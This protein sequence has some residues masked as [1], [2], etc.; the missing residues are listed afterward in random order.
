[1]IGLL[2]TVAAAGDSAVSLKDAFANGSVSGTLKTY[3]FMQTFD[4]AG[5]NG[6]DIWT[7]GGN[8]KYETGN[9]YGLK[10][11]ANFQASA[12]GHKDDD[13]NKTSGSG[14]SGETRFF[15]GVGQGAYDN[16]TSTIMKMIPTMQLICGQDS[17]TL[18]N[19]AHDVWLLLDTA[20]K[21]NVYMGLT[22]QS[23]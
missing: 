2:A 8:L 9:L 7:Y 1:M 14:N 21:A 23:G 13:D 4:G 10:L 11:G 3:Y 17:S 15:R 12:V 5:K 19:D 6:S 20:D 16:Y 22:L 18:F